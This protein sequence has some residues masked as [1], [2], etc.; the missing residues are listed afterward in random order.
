MQTVSASE[1][2]VSF[3]YRVQRTKRLTISTETVSLYIFKKYCRTFKYRGLYLI[4]GAPVLR[5]KKGLLHLN[6]VFS[7]SLLLQDIGTRAISVF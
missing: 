3:C 6:S 4:K 2:Q 7:R 5:V 1:T